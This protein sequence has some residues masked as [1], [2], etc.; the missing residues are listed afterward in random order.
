MERLV[1]LSIIITHQKTLLS[2]SS[3]K[4]M[5]VCALDCLFVCYVLL[6]I[7]FFFGGFITTCGFPIVFRFPSLGPKIFLNN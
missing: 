6:S 4:H 3:S 1:P 7:W 2:S 5:Y